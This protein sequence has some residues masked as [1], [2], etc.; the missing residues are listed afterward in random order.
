MER[1]PL[2]DLARVEPE[3]RQARAEAMLGV[4]ERA[5]YVRGPEVAG[6]E[7]ELATYLGLAEVV[8]VANGTDALEIALRSLGLAEGDAVATVANAGMYATTAILRA[9][10]RPIFVDVEPETLC[11]APA[12]V[13]EALE[14]GARAVVVT[15]LY[16]RLAR[17]EEIVA[18]AHRHGA[19]V[20]EDCAQ[21]IGARRGGIAA[22]AFGDVAAYSFY[23]TKNLG[24]LGDAGAVACREA[25]RA[26]RV[27]ELAQYGW[28]TKYRVARAGGRNS[29]MDE[30]QAAVLRVGLAELDGWND[31]RRAIAADY[32][33]ALPAHAGRLLASGDADFVA[34]LAVVVFEDRDAAR[35]RLAEGL[36][37]TE[38][39]YP[40]PDHRQPVWGD[41]FADVRLPVTEAAT[42]RILT[43]PLFPELTDA[44]VERVCEVLRGL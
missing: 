16:G 1:V 25:D 31:R 19:A 9:G 40:I 41:G 22:G 15:H 13:E 35:A 32:A 14:R 17:V 12:S 26:V 20:L 44:E 24:A 43:L 39:H 30:I 33:A 36:V 29:R 10:L 5:W 42:D 6:F 21:A 4:A 23:P 18:I 7:A 11:A 27:R 38:V 2:N 8:G 3:V 37:D 28:D 34:H